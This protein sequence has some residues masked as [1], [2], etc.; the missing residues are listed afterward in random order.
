MVV[1]YHYYNYYFLAIFIVKLVS[2]FKILH[3]INDISAQ[4]ESNSKGKLVEFW[5]S[6]DE[7]PV[8]IAD[9]QVTVKPIPI[10]G[11]QVMYPTNVLDDTT[12]S[13]KILYFWQTTTTPALISSTFSTKILS[14]DVT[15]LTVETPTSTL[16]N[17]IPNHSQ[18]SIK[19]IDEIYGKQSRVLIKF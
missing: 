12:S 3:G 6:F 9:I 19:R 11:T 2:T 1:Y 5:P 13:T 17:Y 15:N 7:E 8:K 18:E 4:D 14:L 10:G 16:K